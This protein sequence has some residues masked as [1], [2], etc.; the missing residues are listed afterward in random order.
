MEHLYTTTDLTWATPVDIMD[1]CSSLAAW[2]HTKKVATTLRLC[3]Q[4]GT[5]PKH[6]PKPPVTSLPLEI[7]EMIIQGFFDQEL[8][9]QRECWR[10]WQACAECRCDHTP[11][12]DGFTHPDPDLIPEDMWAGVAHYLH[13]CLKEDEETLINMTDHE[14]ASYC[15]HSKAV[16]LC[17]SRTWLWSQIFALPS[18]FPALDDVLRK[19]FGLAVLIARQN[20]RSHSLQSSLT[21]LNE[22]SRKFIPQ[23]YIVPMKD[24]PDE[25]LDSDFHAEETIEDT[26]DG[27]D[28]VW[29][30]INITKFIDPNMFVLTPELAQRFREALRKLKLAPKLNDAQIVYTEPSLLPEWDLQDKAVIRKRLEDEEAGK[31]PKLLNLVKAGVNWKN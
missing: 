6:C 4:L 31:W 11:D 1:L 5:G 7:T 29:A 13:K 28:G 24:M 26:L 21:D 15:S 12:W 30:Q 2:Y 17:D 9:V 8:I 20:G 22:T 10:M 14:A 27:S 25:D 16:H 23:A 3:R 19:D 18:G